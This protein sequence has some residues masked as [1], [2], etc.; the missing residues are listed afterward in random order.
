VRQDGGNNVPED[1]LK[2]SRPKPAPDLEAAHL[3]ATQSLN[4]HPRHFRRSCYNS[5]AIR[6]VFALMA[7]GRGCKWGP[8]MPYIGNESVEQERHQ[9]LLLRSR[10]YILERRA[11]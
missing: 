9:Q 4:S 10:R 2:A 11:S 1:I 8:L 7:L 3:R 5:P 6:G